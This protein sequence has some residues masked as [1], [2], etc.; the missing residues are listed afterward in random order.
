MRISPHNPLRYHTAALF[1]G[2]AFLATFSTARSTDVILTGNFLRVGINDSGGLIDGGF[3]VGITQSATGNSTFPSADF[4][5]PGSP[6][7]FYSIGYNNG[8]GNVTAVA[9]YEFDPSNPFSA[10]TT[11]TSAGSTLSASTSGTFGPLSISQTLS[12]GMSGSIINFSVTLTN[13]GGTSLTNVVYARGLDPD[14]DVNAGGSYSTTN[15][16]VNGNLVTAFGPTTGWTIGI[17]SNSAITHTPSVREDW[18]TDPYMLLNSM[19]DGDGDNAINIAWNVGTLAA[20]QSSTIQ[21]S[22]Q[23]SAIPEP[24]TYA[25]CVGLAAVALVWRRSRRVERG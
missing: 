22:Y 23:I 11:N 14:Q 6:F 25:A 13:T 19:N 4:L 9:G 20:G 15:A 16:V 7:E 3:T 8:A 12:F 21:F 18:S 2:L 10:T 24:S 5:T 1:A 17:F